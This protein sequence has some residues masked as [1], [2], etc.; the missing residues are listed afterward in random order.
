MKQKFY[1]ALKF[2]Y[3]ALFSGFQCDQIFFDASIINAQKFVEVCC[4]VDVIR[5]AFRSFFNRKLIYRAI[6]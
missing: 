2:F 4:H 6:I 3:V 1:A 5:F